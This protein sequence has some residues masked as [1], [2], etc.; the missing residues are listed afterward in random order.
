MS[1]IGDGLRF[2]VAIVHDAKQPVQ[3]MLLCVVPPFLQKLYQDKV[4]APDLIELVKGSGEVDPSS[5]PP[6]KVCFAQVI[7]I[8]LMYH[9][10]L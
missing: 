9:R 3:S 10:F 5:F 8:A 7:I 4:G 6:Q 2:V 1:F